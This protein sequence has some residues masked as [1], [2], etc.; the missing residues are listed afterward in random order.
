MNRSVLIVTPF[1]APQN[2]AAVFRV[3]KLAKYLP[4]FGWKPV[5]LTA[6]THYEYNED[7]GL[8]SDLSPEVEI[9]RSRYI[10]PTVRG[11]RMALGGCDRTFKSLKGKS[12]GAS[13]TTRQSKSNV[14]TRSYHYLLKNLFTS[15]D[16]YW[17]WAKTATRKARQIMKEREI[18][19]V[20]TTAP[21]LSSL[22]IGES[23]HKDGAAWVADFRDPIAY[24][25]QL[26]SEVARVLHRQRKIVCNT[27]A[28]ADAITLAASSTVSI[29]R[30]MFG[31]RGVDPVFIPTGIDQDILENQGLPSNQ[32]RPYLL[33]AGEILPEFDTVFWEVFAKVVANTTIRNK[34]IKVLV[35]GSL[36]LNR[37]R[38][39]PVLEQ[40]AL[41][42]YVEFRDQMSQREGYKLLRNAVAGLLV[43][44]VNSRWW[45]NAAKMTD[46][47]GMR[48][49]VVAVVPDPSEART[50]LTR[51]RLGIFLDGS[52]D[53]R[54]RILAD[55][56]LGK[57]TL[58][59]PDETECEL[60]TARR[61]VQS[62]AELFESLS[63]RRPN[64]TKSICL[65]KLVSARS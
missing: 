60:Y 62:F 61:Q 40:F 28:H 65:P 7:A 26:S 47:I 10:E 3:H 1:F 25:Q 29:Y 51:S 12:P 27:L 20:F 17:T 31:T 8:L 32:N 30:D 48:K 38:L 46:Y 4:L 2:H 54:A 33:F 41:Q 35:V 24:T 52:P 6:D 42:E 53:N 55:F 45:T 16:T 23:L 58:S 34:G 50:A 22:L 39:A 13:P 5:V 63:W 37:P 15:P 36:A 56:L 14:L 64:P 9:I 18:R 11:V 44:G 43:P 59:A 49:P 57:L 19:L 21:P